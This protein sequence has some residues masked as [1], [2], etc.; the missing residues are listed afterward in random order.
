VRTMPH[1]PYL[2]SI[3][4]F[5]VADGICCRC[6]WCGL[7]NFQSITQMTAAPTCLFPLRWSR[8]KKEFHVH[9]LHSSKSLPLAHTFT[10][11]SYLCLTCK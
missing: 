9:D 7:P 4:I 3:D 2:P 5:S 10:L 11:W 8:A 6:R 1:A